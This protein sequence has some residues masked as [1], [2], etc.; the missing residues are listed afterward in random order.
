M[1]GHFLQFMADNIDH[2]IQTLDGLNTIHGMRMI[3]AVTQTPGIKCTSIIIPCVEVT[4]EDAAVAKV[5]IHFNKTVERFNIN[6]ENLSEISKDDSSRNTDILWK[7]SCLLYPTAPAWN[8]IM[9]LIHHGEY[10][11]QSSMTFLPM[12]DMD[13]TI[14]SWIYSTLHFVAMTYIF[15]FDQPLWMKA[16]HIIDSEPSTSRIKNIVLHL[17][18]LYM[19]MSFFLKAL[20][21]L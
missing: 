17:G 9:Q 21:I 11:G 13:P 5:G 15:I 18:A 12:I 2:S 19:E 6:Y 1:Q 20:G 7:L 4:V 10:P 3:K 14:A 16:Q 8:G